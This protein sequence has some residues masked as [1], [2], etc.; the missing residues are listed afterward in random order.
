MR[1]RDPFYQEYRRQSKQKII[2]ALVDFFRD[3]KLGIRNLP[4]SLAILKF[5]EQVR[6]LT[7]A[8]ISVE[9]GELVALQQ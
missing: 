8:K 7:S 1:E 5:L 9:D 6:L 2:K 4:V 3:Y